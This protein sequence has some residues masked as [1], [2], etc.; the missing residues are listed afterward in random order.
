MPCS[1]YSTMPPPL[2]AYG[3]RLRALLPS[4]WPLIPTTALDALDAGATLHADN[5]RWAEYAIAAL[6]P[7]SHLRPA[8]LDPDNTL[9]RANRDW[10]TPGALGDAAARWLDLVRAEPKAADALARF[11]RTPPPPGS[12]PQ[13]PDAAG[14]RDRRPPRCL[15]QPLLVCHPLAH[16][17]P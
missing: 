3:A 6:L 13:A 8:D 9:N 4:V 10:L 17:S 12:A 2:F 16:P 15:R 5:S 7:T 1:S 14:A 11:A